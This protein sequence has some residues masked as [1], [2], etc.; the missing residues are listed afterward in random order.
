M[1]VAG[2]AAILQGSTFSVVRPQASGERTLPQVRIVD[3]G[4]NT[5]LETPDWK[6]LEHK[7][8]WQIRKA[9]QYGCRHAWCSIAKHFEQCLTLFGGVPT[10]GR[11][12]EVIDGKRVLKLSNGIAFQNL[13]KDEGA[14]VLEIKS[15]QLHTCNDTTAEFLAALDGKRDLDA[16]VA[17]LEQKFDVD[18]AVLQAD[19][20]VL[21]HRLITQGIIV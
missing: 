14:V 5:G 3:V 16:V 1:V 20:A 9:W 19:L 8:E 6:Y 7:V 4:A 11:G 10:V 12:F 17:A 21:A 18:F 2:R 13:G 15:G